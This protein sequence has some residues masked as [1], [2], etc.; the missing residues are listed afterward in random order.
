MRFVISMD[1][2]GSK[3]ICLVADKD[4]TL[5]GRGIGGPTNSN[6]CSGKT[7]EKSIE[8]ALTQAL[9]MA[10]I[11]NYD[12]VLE[13]N[14]ALVTNRIKAKEYIG[15][16]LNGKTKINFHSEYEFSI[17][18]AILEKEGGLVQAGTGSFAFLRSGDFAGRTGGWGAVAGDDGSGYYIGRKALKA[19]TRMIDGIGMPT[20][21]MERIPE[22]FKMKDFRQFLRK[23]NTLPFSRQRIVLAQICPVVGICTDA[24]DQVAIEILEKA[25]THLA[26]LLAVLIKKAGMKDIKATVSGGV[27]KTSPILYSSFKHHLLQEVPDVI[28][29]PPLFEPVIG[30]VLIGLE[31]SGFP[32]RD[33]LD[34]L[35]TKFA[36]YIYRRNLFQPEA[37]EYGRFD[38][39][40]NL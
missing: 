35:K 21:L 18:G 19:C 31:N 2:G 23:T 7:V 11:K 29:I 14:A 4:G 34:E 8:T 24:G 30:G 36:D 12:E 32:V 33:R 20:I 25:G 27:W 39:K 10:C 9:Q 17:Y 13:V 26:Q 3:L 22:A 6:F 38:Q 37:G 5:V 1:G 40:Q 16:I 28:L 15:N